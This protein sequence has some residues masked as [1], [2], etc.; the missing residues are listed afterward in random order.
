[1]YVKPQEMTINTIKNDL[2]TLVGSTQYQFVNVLGSTVE[3]DGGGGDFYWDGLSTQTSDDYN[4]I[5]PSIGA[6]RWLRVVTTDAGDSNGSLRICFAQGVASYSEFTNIRK[7]GFN[8][9]LHYRYFAPAANMTRKELCDLARSAGLSVIINLDPYNGTGATAVIDEIDS[10]PAVIGYYLFDEP[11]GKNPPISITV[12]ESKIADCRA[13]T[14]KQLYTSMTVEN[15]LNPLVSL[16]FDVYLL[17]VYYMISDAFTNYNGNGVMNTFNYNKMGTQTALYKELYGDK[18]IIPIATTFIGGGGKYGIPPNEKDLLAWQRKFYSYFPEHNNVAAFIWDIGGDITVSV[19]TNTTLLNFAHEIN[20]D[21]I[22]GQRGNSATFI[23]STMKPA[24]LIHN[25]LPRD[26]DGTLEGVNDDIRYYS[27]INAGAGLDAR[28]QTFG[29]QGISVRKTGGTIAYRCPKVS[30][31]RILGTYQNYADTTTATF[32]LITST[33][34][35]FYF[36]ATSNNIQIL[37]TNS[38]TANLSSVELW[39]T[40]DA[41]SYFQSFGIRFLPNAAYPNFFK[42]LRNTYI[43]GF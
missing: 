5:Q 15:Q 21:A 6:G 16:K 29:T 38:N 4:V 43:A 30:K 13:H 26:K 40:S 7:A 37:G 14:N 27:I 42:F 25:Q 2:K 19:N 9:I 17:S 18:T 28:R 22:R 10:H 20:S 34:D 11:D 3:G 23:Y 41:N 24:E 32:Q 1:M 35:Y 33:A 12:Q 39:G 36:D 31:I 8:C